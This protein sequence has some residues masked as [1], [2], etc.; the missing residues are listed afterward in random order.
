MTTTDLERTLE[1]MGAAGWSAP[2]Q[3]AS[4][5]AASVPASI[6]AVPAVSSAARRV[7]P[8]DVRAA[9]T[10][11]DEDRRLIG[12]SW[13]H[14]DVS[15]LI[16]HSIERHGLLTIEGRLWCTDDEDAGRPIDVVWTHED[17]VLGHVR[18]HEGD[19]FSL[20]G[21]PVPGWTLEI[22]VEGRPTVLVEDPGA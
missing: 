17:H 6:D 15:L 13:E 12:H 20:E 4:D 7:E 10:L 9:S 5:E 21:A 8:S 18:V 3:P 14:V 16:E 22:H 2:P 11:I 1:W 19:V